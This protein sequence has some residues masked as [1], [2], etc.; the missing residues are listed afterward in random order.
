[1]T[2]GP[3]PVEVRRAEFRESQPVLPKAREQG[4]PL[5]AWCAGLVDRGHPERGGSIWRRHKIS[6]DF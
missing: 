3:R 4:A 6:A 1:M 2:G 5:V